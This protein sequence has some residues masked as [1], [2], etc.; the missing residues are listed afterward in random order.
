MGCGPWSEE[1]AREAP[2]AAQ[3]FDRTLTWES[4][5]SQIPDGLEAEDSIALASRILE[6]WLREQVIMHQAELE[7]DASELDF[8]EEL[9]AYR[10]ALIQHHYEERY[11]AERLN[12]RV[13]EAEARAFYDAQPDLFPLNDYVVRAKFLHLPNDGRKLDKAR[14]LF[15]SSDSLLAAPLETWCVE[16]GAAYSID[17]EI[18]WMLDELLREVPLQLYR[19]ERQIADR[20]LIAFEQD[21]RIYWLQFLEHSLKGAPAPFEVVQERIEELILHARRTQLLANLQDRLLEK[22][23]TEGA[24]LRLEPPLP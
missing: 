10:N 23:H 6:G 3:A 18:W 14:V 2:I 8:T 13:T 20:R 9:E 15:T 4:L 1:D 5:E 22:A 19:P 21:D 24:I 17:P 11:V 16:N 7:L 12:D